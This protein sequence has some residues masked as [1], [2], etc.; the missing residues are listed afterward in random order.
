MSDPLVQSIHPCGGVSNFGHGAAC[1]LLVQDNLVQGKPFWADPVASPVA[2]G[3][4]NARQGVG[5]GFPQLE[6]RASPS[7]DRATG[8]RPKMPKPRRR[9][10][11]R[12][13]LL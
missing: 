10:I 5:W 9:P 4:R 2:R 3:R 11:G 7:G 8:N 1:R 13:S 12:G 6:V